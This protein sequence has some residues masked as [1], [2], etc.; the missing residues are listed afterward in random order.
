M[1]ARAESGRTLRAAVT[2]LAQAVVE[3]D[4]AKLLAR[5]PQSRRAPPAPE[6]RN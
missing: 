1:C 6:K 2:Q 4:P 3:V 5:P